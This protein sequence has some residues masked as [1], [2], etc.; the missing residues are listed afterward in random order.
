MGGIT[1]SGSDGVGMDSSGG[2]G[3]TP[4]RGGER[5]QGSLSRRSFSAEYKLQVLAKVRNLRASGRGRLQEFLREEGL[6]TSHLAEWRK[7]LARGRFGEFRRG[8]P[9]RSRED[10]FAEIRLSKHR[11]R[12][13]E[14]KLRDAERMILI[15]KK[16]I[17]AAALR[18][19]RRDRG[20]LSEL[21]AQVESQASISAACQALGLS[22][23]D[24]YRTV[25]PLRAG[26]DGP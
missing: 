1:G 25:K 22:R 4:V 24:Y 14:K 9:E 17:L 26:K 15:Q 3:E 18:A 13:L 5:K 11:L 21:M 19:E 6:L 10:L 7:Q 23:R 16:Y 12:S 20:L 8:R 2:R